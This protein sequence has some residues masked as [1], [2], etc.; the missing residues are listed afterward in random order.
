MRKLALLLLAGIALASPAFAQQ[1]GSGFG[2]QCPVALPLGAGFANTA[3][4]P[5][6]TTLNIWDGSQCVKW[7]TLNQTAHTIALASGA[8]TINPVPGTTGISVI[9]TTD[10]SWTAFGSPAIVSAVH[11]NQNANVAFTLNDLSASTNA[12]PAAAVGYG[13]VTTNGNEVFGT[14]ALAE[15]AAT[16]GGVAIGSEITCRNNSG[17]APDTTLPP[18]VA[19][20]TSTSV[21]NGLQVT[22]GGGNNSSIGIW[23][24]HEGGSSQKFN[25]G[26][27]FGA[28]SVAQYP[29][30]IGSQSGITSQIVGTGFNFDPTGQLNQTAAASLT[31]TLSV[32]GSGSFAATS[33]VNSTNSRS[34]LVGNNSFNTLIWQSAGGGIGFSTGGSTGFAGGTIRGDYGI[35]NGTGWTFSGGVGLA[36]STSG[37]LIVKSPVAAGSNTLTLPAGTTDFSA[38]GGASQVVKQTT[39]GG[40]LTVAQL[41][42]TDL[43]DTAAPTAW[44]P[45]DASGASLTFTGVAANYVKNGKQVTV[46]FR[47]I[48]PTTAN[49]NAMSISGLPFATYT[50]SVV[51]IVAAGANTTTAFG[52]LFITANQNST[53]FSLFNTSGTPTNVQLSGAT[54]VGSFTYISN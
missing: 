54:I 46:Q 18:N 32:T 21:C 20:G 3:A 43:S 27:Y 40:A 34:S 35:T 33:Y 19:I 2:P 22:S 37:A 41:A 15:L 16:G 26:L 45:A 48:Y 49:S 17:N 53:T 50:G 12:L 11:G 28:N 5:T 38:T 1:A 14:Y 4:A 47:F 9:E 42:T 8:I 29:I 25:T 44:T 13:K 23:V 36:G 52:L 10:T 39:S 6:G 31:N 51:P 7:A 24:N 30:Y